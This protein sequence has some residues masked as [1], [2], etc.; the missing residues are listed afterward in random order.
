M[1]TVNIYMIQTTRNFLYHLFCFAFCLN[2]GF[3]KFSLLLKAIKMAY[4]L[5]VLGFKEYWHPLPQLTCL[6]KQYSLSTYMSG[7]ILGT[8]IAVR[9]SGGIAPGGHCFD[10]CQASFLYVISFLKYIP[11]YLKSIF[12]Q[13]IFFIEIEV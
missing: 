6:I 1:P 2:E 8:L 10:C 13:F 3:F 7:L 9:F 4:L 11:L 5:K 12:L